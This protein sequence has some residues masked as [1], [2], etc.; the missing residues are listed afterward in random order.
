MRV[1]RALA[2]TSANVA[3]VSPIRAIAPPAQ[4]ELDFLGPVPG[5]FVL[6]VESRCRRDPEGLPGDANRERVP[7]LDGPRE[8]AQFGGELPGGIR[9]LQVSLTATWHM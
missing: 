5:A 7:A 2:C 6:H 8:A 1:P 9:P 3:G 4:L